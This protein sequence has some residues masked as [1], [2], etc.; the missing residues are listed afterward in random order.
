MKKTEKKKRAVSMVLAMLSVVMLLGCASQNGKEPEEKG[1]GQSEGDSTKWTLGVLYLDQE[2]LMSYCSAGCKAYAEEHDYVKLVEYNAN[3]D[4][5]TQLKQC[6]NLI[7]QGV[8]AICLTPVDGNGCDQMISVCEEA[9]IPLIAFH[10]FVYGDVLTNVGFNNVGFGEMQVEQ[11][12]SL[13][14]KKGNVAIMCGKLDNQNAVE[15]IDGNKKAL[16]KYPDMEVVDEQVGNWNR[17]DAMSIAEN[18]INSGLDIDVIISN[19]DAMAIGIALAYEN[20]G[21]DRPVII[22]VGGTQEGMEALMDGQMDAT[23]FQPAF[24]N[25]YDTMELAIKYLEGEKLDETYKTDGF[26]IT[27]E[28]V[29]ELYEETYGE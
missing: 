13:C 21:I 8:D 14:G 18:W 24:Q 12:A 28:N 26:L 15:R 16:E 20:A 25:G 7:T 9:G 1:T 3:K 17:D 27:K 6:E 10:A 23:V 19:N 2:V 4:V 5:T 22:G 11:A 29:E